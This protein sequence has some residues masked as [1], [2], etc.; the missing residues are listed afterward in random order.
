MPARNHDGKQGKSRVSL[1]DL[2][3]DN[4]LCNFGKGTDNPLFHKTR[5]G[6]NR[7]HTRLVFG[8]SYTKQVSYSRATPW[9]VLVLGF[10]LEHQP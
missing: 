4:F 7:F 10:H 3:Q 1:G 6:E 5:V 9:N 2:G 8:D